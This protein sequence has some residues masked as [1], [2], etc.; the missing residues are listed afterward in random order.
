VLGLIG[1]PIAASLAAAWYYLPL[2]ALLAWIL[3][4]S[5]LLCFRRRKPVPHG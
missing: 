3:V 2:F 4:A 1:F 5:L